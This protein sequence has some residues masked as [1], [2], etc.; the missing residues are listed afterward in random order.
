MEGSLLFANRYV[1]RGIRRAAGWN[2]QPQASAGVTGAGGT[3]AAGVWSNLELSTH[4]DGSLTELRRHRWGVSEYDVWAEGSRRFAWVDVAAGFIW[5]EY[6]GAGGSAGTGELYARVRGMTRGQV[7]L[8]PEVSVWYDPARRNAG[9]L[10][11]SLTSPLL[12]LPFLKPAVVAYTALDAG[13][14][15]GRPDRPSALA[16]SSFRESGLAYG[17]VSTGIR[18]RSGTPVGDVFANLSGHLLVARDSATR[19]RTIPAT[20][21]SRRVR[22]YVMLE[23]GISW[24]RSPEH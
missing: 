24:P 19:R 4:R 7:R 12:A 17:Q 2:A 20:D 1:W 13:L 9:Y 23:L 16:R 18:V 22:A 10:E 6:R 14:V 5:Y 3:L 11:A 21:P 8:S 15:L